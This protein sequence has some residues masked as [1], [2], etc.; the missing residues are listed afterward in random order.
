[1]YCIYR[2]TPEDEVFEILSCSLRHV[3]SES[4]TD[5]LEICGARLAWVYGMITDNLPWKLLQIDSLR[6]T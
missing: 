1:M 4:Y 5:L 3:R 6:P 2:A